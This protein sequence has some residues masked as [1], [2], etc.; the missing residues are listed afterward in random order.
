M[1][2]ISTASAATAPDF[3]RELLTLFF[4]GL[5]DDLSAGIVFASAM[6]QGGLNVLGQVLCAGIIGIILA[7]SSS[8][9]RAGCCDS[10]SR[11]TRFAEPAEIL[12][13][14]IPLVGVAIDRRDEGRLP[15]HGQAHISG[16]EVGVD[17]VAA[18]QNRLPL[19]AG[20]RLRDARRFGDARHNPA[21]LLLFPRFFFLLLLLLTNDVPD[22]V[23]LALQLLVFLF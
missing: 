1:A 14:I 5:V 7:G 21:A 8:L 6:L 12:G 17:R 15:A 23:K 13:R 4:G 10:Q 22:L 11:I 16:R 18:F 2:A 19:L 9:V 3:R 20:V